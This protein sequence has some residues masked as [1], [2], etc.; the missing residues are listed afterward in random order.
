MDQQ[1]F[2]AQ[3][4]LEHAHGDGTW[5]PMVEERSHHDAADHDVERG[6]ARRRIFRCTSCGEAATLVPGDEGDA[7]PQ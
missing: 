1:R 7:E 5:A 6:W 4:R 2:L 3:Y